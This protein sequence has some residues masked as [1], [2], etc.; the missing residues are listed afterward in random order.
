MERA[1]RTWRIYG[2]VSAHA[3]VVIAIWAFSMT[4]QRHIFGTIDIQRVDV[5]EPNGTLQMV[6]SDQT[7]FPGA[8]VKGK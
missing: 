2:A 8:I 6:I 3:F 7:R 1:L 5:V 4:R